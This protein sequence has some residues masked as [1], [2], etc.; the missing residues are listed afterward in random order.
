MLCF[1]YITAIKNS[2][3]LFSEKAVFKAVLPKV[4]VH[5]YYTLLVNFHL[6]FF[7]FLYRLSLNFHQLFLTDMQERVLHVLVH[8]SEN[9]G[10]CLSVAD[11]KTE[12]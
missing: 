9:N 4:Q 11:Q 8:N 5:I 1:L 2:N 6:G 10:F 3:K 12:N 7:F